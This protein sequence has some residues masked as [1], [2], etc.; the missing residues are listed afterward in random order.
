M[1][2]ILLLCIVPQP[3]ASINRSVGLVHVNHFYDDKGELVHD[4]V[5]FYDWD[6]VAERYQVRAWRIMCECASH[7]RIA[8]PVRDWRDGT[9]LSTWCER[10]QPYLIRARNFTESWTQQDPEM[11]ERAIL[12]EAKRIPLE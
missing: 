5:I 11:L 10:D 6:K 7:T 3:E 2:A 4:Q 12:V 1:I 8:G 9:F